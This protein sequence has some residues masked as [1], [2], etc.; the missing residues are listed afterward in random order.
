M[1]AVRW[2][3]SNEP[4][5]DSIIATFNGKMAKECSVALILENGVELVKERSSK[6]T[7]QFSI[8]SIKQVFYKS[9]IPKEMLDLIEIRPITFGQ[10]SFDLNFSFQLDSPF[11][12]SE[13]A[14]VAATIVSKFSGTEAVNCVHKEL[15]TENWNFTREENKCTKE[16][17][18]LD[19]RLAKYKGLNEVEASYTTVESAIVKCKQEEDELRKLNELLAAYNES[20][21]LITEK[22]KVLTAIGDVPDIKRYEYLSEQFDVAVT[23]DDLFYNYTELTKDITAKNSI[24]QACACYDS[25][26]V[27]HDNIKVGYNK[28]G[29]NVLIFA[30]YLVVNNSIVDKCLHEKIAATKNIVALLTKHVAIKNDFVACNKLDTMFFAYSCMYNKVKIAEGARDVLKANYNFDTY[31]AAITCGTLNEKLIDTELKIKNGETYVQQLQAFTDAAEAGIEDLWLSVGYK[32]PT[33]NTK[34]NGGSHEN[35]N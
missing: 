19:L 25:G 16:I 12:I 22:T 10:L 30:Q 18:S 5:G 17:E 1:Y 9:D 4:K 8:P 7:T 32:C 6:G 33:C 24:A 27:Q 14:S 11:L 13:P 26:I 34:L 23:M 28:F 3:I 21:K 20:V 15:E 35:C 29:E 2:F 31:S